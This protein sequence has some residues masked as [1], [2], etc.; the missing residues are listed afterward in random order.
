MVQGPEI[1]HGRLPKTEKDDDHSHRADDRTDGVFCKSRKR[2]AIEATTVMD[3]VAA[4][5][6]RSIRIG[7]SD[8]GDED[9]IKLAKMVH[10]QVATSEKRGAQG[11]C[12]SGQGK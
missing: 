10:D 6:A 1:V 4:R 5:K 2:K 7:I 9:N 11:R 3:Q 12:T 8:F